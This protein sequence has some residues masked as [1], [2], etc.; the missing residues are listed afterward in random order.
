[1]L[2]ETGHIAVA[3]ANRLFKAVARTLI[4]WS[5]HNWAELLECEIKCF[6]ATGCN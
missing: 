2:G 6:G 3:T 4:I 1:M 5:I